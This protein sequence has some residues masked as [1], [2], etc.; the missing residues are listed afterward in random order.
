[1]KKLF[2][3][4]TAACTI[5]AGCSNDEP[6]LENTD[7]IPDKTTVPSMPGMTQAETLAANGQIAFRH[8]LLCSCKP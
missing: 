2:F 4:L 7:E 5:F 6:D 8:G 3:A 1:M